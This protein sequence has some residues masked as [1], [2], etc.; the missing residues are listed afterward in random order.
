MWE[1]NTGLFFF[2]MSCAYRN[3][4]IWIVSTPTYIV[5]RVSAVVL[6]AFVPHTDVSRP[7]R[8]HEALLIGEIPWS[9][10]GHL[11]SQPNA[12]AQ[13]LSLIHI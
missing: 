1:K 6:H 4:Y 11:T 7:F 5:T 10:G 2:W 3:R 8:G 9:Q 12:S 13:L